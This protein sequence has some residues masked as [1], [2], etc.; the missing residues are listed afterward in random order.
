MGCGEEESIPADIVDVNEI[1]CPSCDRDREQNMEDGP[2]IP[3]QS[4]MQEE[5]T[6]PVVENPNPSEETEEPAQEPE[7][8]QNKPEPEPEP[9]QRPTCQ[10]QS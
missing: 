3:G 9:E 8:E 5:P 6:T 2:A 4:T 10:R 7:T 1:P